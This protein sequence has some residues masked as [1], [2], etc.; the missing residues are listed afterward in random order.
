[1]KEMTVAARLE[2]IEVVT[3]FID[4]FLEDADC[5][6]KTQMQI[7]VAVDEV[8][9]NIAHYAYPDGEGM[10]TVSIEEKENTVQIFFRDSGIPYDPLTAKAP[11]LSLS[12]EDRPIGGLG[13]HM[14]KKMM[15]AVSYRYENGQNMLTLQKMLQKG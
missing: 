15:D 9:S 14:V 11:D 13:I 12:A 4:A 1:M 10:V 3:A 5:P 2:N 8:M 7:D 6:V